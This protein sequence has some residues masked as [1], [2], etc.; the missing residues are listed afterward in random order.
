MNFT[1]NPK[2]STKAKET[3]TACPSSHQSPKRTS[4]ARRRSLKPRRTNE[5]LAVPQLGLTVGTS[6]DA[7]PHEVTHGV[8]GGRVFSPPSCRSLNQVFFFLPQSTSTEIRDI[9]GFQNEK[10]CECLEQ[11]LLIK[12]LRLTVPSS[13]I[14]LEEG[15]VL[16]FTTLLSGGFIFTLGCKCS[17]NSRCCVLETNDRGQTCR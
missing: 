1:R 9:S 10:S 6:R 8:A 3:R 7:A 16:Q 15:V 11:R 2:S 17:C 5:T 13:D 12:L 4:P 14:D